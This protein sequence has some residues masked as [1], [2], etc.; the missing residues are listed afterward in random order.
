MN[1]I[2]NKPAMSLWVGG[3]LLIAYMALVLG[4]ALRFEAAS[5][6]R[7]ENAE[8]NE[9]Q[10]VTA[11]VKSC[12][13][14]Q[15]HPISAHRSVIFKIDC[16]FRYAVNGTE[17][18][19]ST[20]TSGAQH[21]L[22]RG[23]APPR[24]AAPM[25][26]WARLHPP[27]SLQVIHYN[28]K[29]P[30]QV[31]LAGGRRAIYHQQRG[32]FAACLQSDFAAG[33]GSI[34]GGSF[35]KLYVIGGVFVN[36]SAPASA[37]VRSPLTSHV[38]NTW[39]SRQTGAGRRV[40]RSDLSYSSQPCPPEVFAQE[41]QSRIATDFSSRRYTTCLSQFRWFRQPRLKRATNATDYSDGSRPNLTVRGWRSVRFEKHPGLPTFP[42][43]VYE[44]VG[45]LLY[46]YL[47]S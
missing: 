6:A 32:D 9:W 47:L 40:R 29:N 17:Y 4:I 1:S 23:A 36:S 41:Q 46:L 7:Q 34:A 43:F 25:D 3:L 24:E 28:P 22:Y 37:A 19:G 16:R 45:L 38:H 2:K 8:W 44:K 13:L 35:D 27:G 5:R 11:H 21:G 26:I 20:V 14:V 33:H 12:F 30:E 10:P 31:S 18:T 15:D 42:G 39:N